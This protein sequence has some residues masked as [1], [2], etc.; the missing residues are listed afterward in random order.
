MKILSIQPKDIHVTFE[1]S[2]DQIKLLLD[3]LDN[4]TMK[5]RNPKLQK[6][7][8]YVIQ[9]FFKQL[10]DMYEDVRE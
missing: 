4:C 8:D 9:D 2:L 7:V 5:F 10:N 3:F 1:M 6:S